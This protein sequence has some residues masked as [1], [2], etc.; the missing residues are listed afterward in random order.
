MGR[1]G[2]GGGRG[3]GQ[4]A[5]YGGYGGYGGDHHGA[6]AEDDA[7][8]E[9]LHGG[10]VPRRA[11]RGRGILGERGGGRHTGGGGYPGGG[12]WG[13]VVGDGAGDGFPLG[14]G[15][16]SAGSGQA[17][18]QAQ[19]RLFGRLRAG[20]SAGSGQALRRGQGRLGGG[21]VDGELDP[22][23]CACDGGDGDEEGGHGVV[24]EQ[25][26]D[27][28][29]PGGQAYGEHYHCAHHGGGYV[30][31]G[32][33]FSEGGGSSK[34]W[35][36]RSAWRRRLFQATHAVMVSARPSARPAS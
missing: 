19:G 33:F 10:I 29:D 7:G 32:P 13:W 9:G 2:W 23:Q 35:P 24:L 22:G 18:R 5:H 11:R 28:G 12:G 6:D 17:L 14:R 16:P 36:W 4:E 27:D 21:L 20:S 3:L 25:D 15:N 8:L 34:G 31:E 30:G 26:G 1:G